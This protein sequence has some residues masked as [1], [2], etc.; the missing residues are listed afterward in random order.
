MTSCVNLKPS[1]LA[2]ESPPEPVITT[3]TSIPGNFLVSLIIAV[4]YLLAVQKNDFDRCRSDI[5]TKLVY[6]VHHLTSK[7]LSVSLGRALRLRLIVN[8]V[9][10][11]ISVV[12]IGR[13]GSAAPCCFL[14]R[15]NGTEE[16]KGFILKIHK[17]V[18]LLGS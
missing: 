6:L 1:Q 14:T 13:A 3:S 11:R 17:P 9:I 18:H 12:L 8:Y 15:L 10:T 2:T 16:L 4:D 5:K 7:W